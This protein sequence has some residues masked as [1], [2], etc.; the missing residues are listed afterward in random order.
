MN[1]HKAERLPWSP[2]GHARH[3]YRYHTIESCPGWIYIVKGFLRGTF[4]SL[5]AA[6][7]AIG[8]WMKGRQNKP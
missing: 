3:S 1:T 7:A 4:D 6:K 5:P 2:E 8:S